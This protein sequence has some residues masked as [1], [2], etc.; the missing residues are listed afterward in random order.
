MVLNLNPVSHVTHLIPYF[1]TDH[2][3]AAFKLQKSLVISYK[4]VS[5]KRT[6]IRNI[7]SLNP[8]SHT[9]HLTLFNTDHTCGASKIQTSSVINYKVI[10]ANEYTSKKF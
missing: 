2:T 5:L 8:N 1:N 7:L 9:T 10:S 3:F 6:H 4:V